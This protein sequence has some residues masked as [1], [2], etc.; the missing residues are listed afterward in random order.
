MR[1]NSSTLNYINENKK[2]IA[3]VTRKLSSRKDHIMIINAENVN[4]DKL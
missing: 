3:K 1:K 2:A 4:D